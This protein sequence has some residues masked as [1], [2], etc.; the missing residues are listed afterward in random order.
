[1][2]RNEL[3]VVETVVSGQPV[4]IRPLRVCCNESELFSE[5]IQRS[6][7]RDVTAKD[8]RGFRCFVRRDMLTEIIRFG[9]G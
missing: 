2:L 4:F 8:A 6:G 9:T 3:I 1:M 5:S 7:L